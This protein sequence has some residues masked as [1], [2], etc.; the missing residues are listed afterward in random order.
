[1][2]LCILQ[3]YNIQLDP[4]FIPDYLFHLVDSRENLD[5]TKDFKHFLFLR[6]RPLLGFTV[7]KLSIDR[8]INSDRT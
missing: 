1:M 4:K 7:A 5:E 3:T 2:C 6:F 8:L